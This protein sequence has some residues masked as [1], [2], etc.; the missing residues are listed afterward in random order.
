M[1]LPDVQTNVDVEGNIVR[2]FHG[3][4]TLVFPRI[5]M[6]SFLRH[7]FENIKNPNYKYVDD[8]SAS[9]IRIEDSNNFDFEKMNFWPAITVARSVTTFSNMFIGDRG[10]NN[11]SRSLGSLFDIHAATGADILSGMLNINV[12]SANSYESETLAWLIAI[13]TK[14]GQRTL[15]EAQFHDIYP[16]KVSQPMVVGS[17]SSIYMTTITMRYTISIEWIKNKIL[18]DIYNGCV[19]IDFDFGMVAG[20]EKCESGLPG[21]EVEIKGG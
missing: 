18:K 7:I 8:I 14:I 11:E 19:K 3:E 13:M 12:Y 9:K 15:R 2:G 5:V 16:E 4:D 17:E 21:N 20:T 10:P 1:E 6:L